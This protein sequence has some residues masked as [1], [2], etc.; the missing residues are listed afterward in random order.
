MKKLQTAVRQLKPQELFAL[1]AEN[2]RLLQWEQQ[3]MERAAALKEAEANPASSG[4]GTCIIR[5]ANTPQ[6]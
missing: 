4:G 3:L 1:Q 6:K 2:E 5:V